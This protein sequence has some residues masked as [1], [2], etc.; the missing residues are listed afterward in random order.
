MQIL[1]QI[2]VFCVFMLNNNA[3]KTKGI[4]VKSIYSLKHA[5]IFLGAIAMLFGSASLA[6]AETLTTQES[7][8]RLEESSRLEESDLLQESAIAT[9]DSFISVKEAN[10]QTKQSVS[11]R[12]ADLLQSDDPQADEPAVTPSDVS[13]PSSTTQYSLMPITSTEGAVVDTP[14]SETALTDDYSDTAYSDTTADNTNYLSQVQTEEDLIFE[15]VGGGDDDVAGEEV[16]QV[17]SP[18]RTTRSGPSYIGI[19]GNIGIG[20]GDTALGEGSFAAFSKIGLTRNISVRPSVLINE[21][22]TILLPVTFDFIPGVTRVTENVS[23]EIGY[24]VSPFIG[25]GAAI[26]TGDDTTVDF[27]ATGGVDVPL[28]DNF[29]GVAAVNVSLFDDPAVGLLLGVGVNFPAL[30]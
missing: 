24:R 23:E 10:N 22:P 8:I 7:A 2:C 4:A 15:D 3:S 28:G 26:S 5:S 11:T 1:V 21:N 14:A 25:A 19:G 20:D 18:G 29:T 13:T 16:A 12:A 17:V 27:L 6:Q 9:N 30:R